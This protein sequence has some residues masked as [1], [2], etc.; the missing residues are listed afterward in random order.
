M[1]LRT[2]RLAIAYG[3]YND[4]VLH[5]R[6]SQEAI[7]PPPLVR[8]KR[9]NLKGPSRAVLAREM[10]ASRVNDCKAI[11]GTVGELG[12]SARLGV[13]RVGRVRRKRGLGG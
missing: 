13:R 1:N 2:L 6:K 5:Q 4:R 7:D 8:G 3:N 10:G 9:E 12:Q 11:G